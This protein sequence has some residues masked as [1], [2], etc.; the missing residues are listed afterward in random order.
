MNG[1]KT[2]LT[3]VIP[4]D[5]RK[6]LGHIKE[7]TGRSITDQL[8]EGGWMSE[9]E[10]VKKLDHQHQIRQRVMETRVG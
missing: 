6:S 8:I 9:R 5:L 4:T 3:L 2:R 1:D 7:I 10:F